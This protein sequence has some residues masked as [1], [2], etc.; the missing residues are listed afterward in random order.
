MYPPPSSISGFFGMA[1]RARRR[2]VCALFAAAVLLGAAAP[3]AHAAGLPAG[4]QRGFVLTAWKSNSY[5]TGADTRISKMA[6]DGSDHAAVFTQWFLDTPTSSKLAPDAART[7]S[8][9]SIV[10]AITRAREAGLQVAVKP[11]VGIRTGSWI[12]AAHPADLGAFWAGYR[13]M[14]LHYADLAQQNGA[15]MLVIGTEMGTLSS[16]ATHWRALIAELRRHFSGKLTYA[17][18]YDEFE[19]V[20][21]WDALDYIGIDAYFALADANN[22]AP[23]TAALARAWTSRGYLDRIAAVS[24]RTGKRVLFTEIGYRG[25]HRTAVHPNVWNAVDS[26]DTDAQARA[27]EAFYEAVA[28]QPW[29]AGAYWW[30]VNTDGW[31]VQDSSPLAKPAEQV[32]R[33]WNQSAQRV[34]DPPRSSQPP[35]VTA[36]SEAGSRSRA[37]YARR[38]THSAVPDVRLRVAMRGRRLHGAVRPWS[39]TTRGR[40]RL[41]V[42]RRRHGHWKHLCSRTLHPRA[43]GRFTHRVRHGRVRVR[44]VFRRGGRVARSRWIYPRA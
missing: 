19:R 39:H 8:D 16:D 4:F 23:P 28:N 38:R 36:A 7:P 5:L 12:G 34:S 3:G 44:V 1:G 11:Q 40:V 35:G 15:S 30:E 37:T 17:A 42:Q 14:L 6:A 43:R 10:H 20:P 13:A 24:R 31:W 18:N 25:I 29:L 22:P 27:Y 33:M 21:F 32:M 41:R 2:V 26:T 9:E